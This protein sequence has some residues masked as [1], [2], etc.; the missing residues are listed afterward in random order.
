MNANKPK[1]RDPFGL[2]NQDKYDANA[3]NR[4]RWGSDDETDPQFAPLDRSGYG[5]GSRNL[6]N[7]LGAAAQA[8]EDASRPSRVMLHTASG[9]ALTVQIAH[10]DGLWIGFVPY[11]GEWR[12]FQASK[13]DD[14]I[15]LLMK[16]F[17]DGPVIRRLSETG[18][19]TV[20]RMVTA[21]HLEAALETYV[22]D[23]C[24]SITPESINDVRY[25]EL[26][27]DAAWEIFSLSTPD[28]PDNPE[29]RA[30][31]K[32][33]VGNRPATLPGLRA[34]WL[35]CQRGIDSRR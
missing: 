30:A 1:S 15:A 23:R 28:F 12:E 2:P 34:A 21:G 16:T 19:L 18:R 6:K 10:R 3:P 14:L 5:L 13:Y 17:D 8:A 26:F 4:K 20:A 27:D 24:P 35:S 31:M 22:K 25:R 7:F 32:E 33:H 11:Q 29:V 9:A